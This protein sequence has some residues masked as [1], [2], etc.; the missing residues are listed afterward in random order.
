[1]NFSDMV[2]EVS[3]R[4]NLTSDAAITRIGRS[5]NEA[6]KEILGGVGLDQR[7]VRQNGVTATT[8]IGQ[9]T[10][11]FGPATPVEKILAVYNTAFTPPLIMLEVSVDTIRQEPVVTDPPSEYAVFQ[12]AQKQATI[13]LNTVPATAFTLT[14]DVLTL[15]PVLAGLLSPVF[16]DEFHNALVYHALAVE[17]DKMEKTQIADKMERRYETRKS[18]LR[19]YFFKS[20]YNDIVQGRNVNLTV[21]RTLPMV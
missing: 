15:A 3:D 9:R 10:L 6:Y 8:T 18:D 21:T 2:F 16:P 19:Y 13:L 11:T 1:M 7:L 20:A 17:Y 12:Y 14:A 4:L 5:I